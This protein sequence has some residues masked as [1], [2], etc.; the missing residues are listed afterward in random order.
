MA[1]LYLQ[2]H[3]K[4]QWNLDDRFAGWTD[5]PLT[6]DSDI[7]AKE[8]AKEIST[9]NIDKAYGS[10]LFRNMDTIAKIFQLFQ[11]NIRCSYILMVEKW[12]NGEAMEMKAQMNSVFT[13]QK[14]LTKDVTESCK[15]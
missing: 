1:K 12:K 11:T 3:L 7:L 5:G 4:S 6:K 15:V 8:F 2:R 9:L 10:S 14:Y 13:P